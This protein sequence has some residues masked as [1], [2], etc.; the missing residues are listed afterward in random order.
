MKHLSSFIFVLFRFYF[1]FTGTKNNLTARKKINLR[2]D[3]PN[4]DDLHYSTIIGNVCSW[5]QKNIQN[6]RQSENSKAAIHHFEKMRL[7]RRQL[8]DS[9]NNNN[10]NRSSLAAN[11]EQVATLSLHVQLSMRHP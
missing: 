7:H 4:T 1:N 3:R 6:Y 5:Q 9:S 2:F 11:F 8:I 10:G